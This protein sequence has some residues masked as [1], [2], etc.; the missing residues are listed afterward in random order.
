[1]VDIKQLIKINLG[2]PLK[3][4]ELRILRLCRLLF[5]PRGHFSA[6]QITANPRNILLVKPSERL[7]NVVLMNSAIDALS[8]AFPDTG[9]DLLLPEAFADLMTDNRRISGIVRAGKKEYIL[10]PFKLV[11]LIGSLR[12]RAYDMAIDCSDV[13][14]HSLTAA[15]YTLLSGARVS[16]GWRLGDRRVFDIEIPRYDQDLHAKDMIPRLFSSIFGGHLSGDP[17]FES[18]LPSSPGKETVVGINCGGRGHKRWPLE[19]FIEL[20]RRLSSEGFG[21]EFI[22]GPDEKGLR[23]SL[24][25]R[26]PDGCRIL[27]EMSIV[28]L[29]ETIKTYSLFISSDT[30]PMH[31]AWTQRVPTIAIFLDSEIE[32]FKPL[33]PGSAA[34]DGKGGLTVDRVY[35]LAI[36]A[37]KRN[38]ASQVP[39][40]ER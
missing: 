37:L 7:G 17:Y 26:L 4:G 34:L 2:M 16:A 18:S 35:E 15:A 25:D 20:G 3:S 5:T 10:N 27:D 12:G 36:K 24:K 1:L 9:I 33:S 28:G 11:K 6:R 39:G 13:N 29:K 8:S 38:R 14:S 22:L 23:Q 30:G 31:L 40:V 21:C 32:K 19:Y